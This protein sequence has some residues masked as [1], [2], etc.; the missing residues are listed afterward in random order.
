MRGASA[1]PPGP[2]ALSLSDPPAKSRNLVDVSTAVVLLLVLIGA[3]FVYR[4]DGL[5]GIVH[6]LAEDSLLFLDILPKVLAG[7]LIGSFA[8]VL[9]PRE[10]V[11]RWVGADSGFSG[12]IIATALGTIMPGGPFTIYPLAGAFLAI[13]AGVG[14]AVA[15]VTSWQL[16]GLNRAVVWEVP[17]FG[18]D[19]VVMRTL[20]SLP[21]PILA[22]FGAQLL[23]RYVPGGPR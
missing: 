1:A 10:L 5:P 22:G 11:S 3:A 16:I 8:S 4:R 7:C 19:F 18:I 21:L 17:F 14:P 20:A 6:I 2:H 12:L 15:F 9:M 23:A 13:G